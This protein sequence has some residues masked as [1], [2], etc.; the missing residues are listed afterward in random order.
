[1]RW[2]CWQIFKYERSVNRFWK[3]VYRPS[4]RLRRQWECTYCGY[5]ISDNTNKL[6]LHVAHDARGFWRCG[7]VE[8][9]AN[10]VI[11]G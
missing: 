10:L 3:D 1:M 11:E 6:Y 4:K 7:G 8:L 2:I 9:P 5:S